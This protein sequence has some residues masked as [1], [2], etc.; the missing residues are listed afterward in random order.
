MSLYWIFLILAI[1]IA[2][3]SDKID[4]AA[5]GSNKLKNGL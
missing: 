1:V 4:V 3:Y 5:N 2:L